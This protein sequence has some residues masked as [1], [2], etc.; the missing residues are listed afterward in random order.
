MG[1]YIEQ[2]YVIFYSEYV[3]SK[4]IETKKSIG[5][6]AF[7]EKHDDLILSTGIIYLDI[8]LH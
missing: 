5:L 4:N 3:F 7:T 1:E 6:I 2:D 8:L